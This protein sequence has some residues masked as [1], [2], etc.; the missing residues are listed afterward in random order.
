MVA[1][2]G[3][4]AS[5]LDRCPPDSNADLRARADAARA[6]VSERTLASDPDAV[7]DTLALVTDMEAAA[8]KC[9]AP[10]EDQ[11]ALQLVL[12]ERRSAS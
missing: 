5:W 3:I 7:D 8:E 1:L 6:Q 4:A 12:K 10:D 11:A 9:G 2:F